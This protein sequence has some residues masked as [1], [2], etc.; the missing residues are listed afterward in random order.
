MRDIRIHLWLVFPVILLMIFMT[1]NLMKSV[2]DA[3][4][5]FIVG[6]NYNF[7]HS[8]ETKFVLKDRHAMLKVRFMSSTNNI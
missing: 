6:V 7:D 2:G 8:K 5:V 1:A 3:I 4:T